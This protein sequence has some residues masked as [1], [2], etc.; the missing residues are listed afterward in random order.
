[1]RYTPE[2]WNATVPVTRAA[3]AL[4]LAGALV[5]AAWSVRRRINPKS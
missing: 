2:G 1:M 5:A 3:M 4:W